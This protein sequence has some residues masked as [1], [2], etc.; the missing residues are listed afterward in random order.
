MRFEPTAVPGVVVVSLD[1]RHDERGFFARAYCVDEFAEHGLELDVVQANLSHNVAAGTIRG[2]HYQDESAPEPK[3]FRCI[4][5][6]TYHVAVDM[7]E[8][9]STHGQWVGVY[10]DDQER[11]AL[12]IPGGCAAGY[13]AMTDAAEVLYL[14]G[15]RYVPG[16]ERG[17]R[18]DDPQIGVE[19]PLPPSVVSEK[20]RSWPLLPASYN[21]T[22]VASTP[23][24]RSMALISST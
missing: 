7:R 8:G 14:T 4:R 18:F 11:H 19:W 16:A 5:G 24:S 15:A 12:Y 21:A 10:L 23:S 3:L 17:L 13:Q 6:R 22:T 9:S 1:A 2:L 20:D